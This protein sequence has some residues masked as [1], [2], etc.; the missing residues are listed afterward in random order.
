[1]FLEFL[2]NN[3]NKNF[4]SYYLS[5]IFCNFLLYNFLNHIKEGGEKMDLTLITAMGTSFVTTL[6]TKGADAPGN[7]LNLAW[8]YAFHGMDS[9]FKQGLIKKESAQKFQNEISENINEIPEENIVNPR[10]SIVMNAM[11]GARNSLEEDSIREMYAKLIASACDSRKQSDL[12][13]SYVEIV[14]Q[15]SPN[16]AKL[17]EQLR[18]LDKT[19]SVEYFTS[20]HDGGEIDLSSN[21][22]LPFVQNYLQTVNGL[23]NLIRLNLVTFAKGRLL[24]DS[25]V[26]T[27]FESPALKLSVVNDAGKFLTKVAADQQ[28]NI[29]IND[30]AYNPVNGIE[31]R[32]SYVE[33]T[34]YGKSFVRICI[35]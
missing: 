31:L 26:Y 8:Q 4:L 23:E 21:F 32:K 13:P 11:E 6:A 24:V 15:L 35:S 22:V 30:S 5:V 1:M 18:V 14:K 17:L 2:N 34:S 9:Y 25:K 33:I 29:N 27:S 28:K 7:T 3:S 10:E 20:P 16:D 19:P 12:H